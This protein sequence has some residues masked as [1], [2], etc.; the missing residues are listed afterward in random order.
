M[1][2]PELQSPSPRTIRVLCVDDHAFLIEGLRG[3]MTAEPDIEF[4]GSLDRADTLPD[5]ADEVDADVVLL[6]IDLPGR[7]AFDAC[8]ELTRRRPR[9]RVVLLSAYVR[10]GYLE[11]ASRC[12][13]HG[14]LSKRDAPS[15]IIA[16]VRRVHAG[17]TVYSESVRARF[18]SSPQR[19]AGESSGDAC[20]R[21]Q[22]LTTRELQILRLIGQG[23]QRADIAKTIHRS[24]KTVDAHRASI[25]DK[26][27]LHDRAELVRFAIREGLVEL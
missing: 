8:E 25:M 4:A 12:Q 21:L 2:P 13:V 16:A 6:D 11:A 1:Q 7:D 18:R 9:T 20:S 24:A 10:D 5:T 19:Q 22:H 26:L 3:R 15:D 17:E 27:G 23:M 14:Y